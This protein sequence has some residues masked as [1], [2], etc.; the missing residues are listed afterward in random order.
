MKGEEIQKT[1]G[2]YEKASPCDF[3]EN[4]PLSSFKGKKQKPLMLVA[5]LAP[6]TV[7]SRAVLLGTKL[8]QGPLSRTPQINR[9]EWGQRPG[10]QFPRGEKSRHLFIHS[11]NMQ[12]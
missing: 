5:S 6:L 4:S 10:P 2:P 11:F 7:A 1:E 3:Q 8:R 12:R 9:P